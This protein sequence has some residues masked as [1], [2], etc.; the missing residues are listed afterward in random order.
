MNG[1]IIKQLASLCRKKY[2]HKRFIQI[3]LLMGF[4]SL[5][6]IAPTVNTY[7]KKLKAKV[8]KAKGIL[9]L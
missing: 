8:K 5:I 4:L 3:D 6:F 1:I 9:A 7:A 2:R